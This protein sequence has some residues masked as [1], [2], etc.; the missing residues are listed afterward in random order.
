[1][2]CEKCGKEIPE[3]SK[4]CLECGNPVG[5]NPPKKRPWLIPVVIISVLLVAGLI[6]GGILLWQNAGS[7]TEKEK[8]TRKKEKKEE[9]VVI[10]EPAENGPT[11]DEMLYDYAA[12]REYLCSSDEIY[13]GHYVWD[14]PERA[15]TL[16]STEGRLPQGPMGFL[17]DDFDLDG[18]REL[19][20]ANIDD[21]GLLEL[22]MYKASEN[23]VELAASIKDF[24]GST[25]PVSVCEECECACF[26]WREDDRIV[27]AVEE[28]GS[29]VLSADGVW[30]RLCTLSYHDGSFA[31]IG[32]FDEEG[33]DFGGYEEEMEKQVRALGIP[34]TIEEILSISD[35]FFTLRENADLFVGVRSSAIEDIYT[36]LNSD[37]EEYYDFGEKLT[38]YENASDIVIS[39]LPD[40]PVWHR[41]PPVWEEEE[42][43]AAPAD[44][45]EYRKRREELASEYGEGCQVGQVLT[46]FVFYDE[47]GTPV[48]ISD[49]LGRAVYINFFT[50][51][52]PYCFYEIPDME[53]ADAAYSADEAVTIMIDLQ[54][55]AAEVEAYAQEYDIGLPI[56]YFDD[57][58]VGSYEI[59]GIPVSIVI[60][61][62]GRIVGFREG[63]SDYAWM[64]KTLDAAVKSE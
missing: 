34:A 29:A 22:E 17:L 58:R 48:H 42:D 51:W 43:P 45:E 49:F 59:T 28:K 57:F 32:S 7:G 61:R 16:Y 60:D 53:A 23:G 52:C 21:E 18:Q 9:T 46:D 39:S 2:I 36:A 55:S 1:M 31:L 64:S 26:T 56:Y 63:Q 54:E 41:T 37:W 40:D 50:T 24:D 10:D 47:I 3:A 27:I 30:T 12:E 38:S 14:S 62:Y 11:A 4:F 33:S 15:F 5:S 25:F 20:F 13:H 19:L 35:P 6:V 44:L 8:K